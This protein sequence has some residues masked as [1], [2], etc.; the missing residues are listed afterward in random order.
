[1]DEL[2]FHG[3]FPHQ[4]ERKKRSPFRW[5][6][7]LKPLPRLPSFKAMNAM[8]HHPTDQS[9]E[10][11]R[12]LISQMETF[13]PSLPLSRQLN[14]V[15]ANAHRNLGQY[16]QAIGVIS[17]FINNKELVS[18]NDADLAAAYY[19]RACYL[20]LSGQSQNAISDLKKCTI[21]EYALKRGSY[22]SC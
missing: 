2:R 14:I 20:V 16:E 6:A 11:I 7:A 4:S 1:L 22:S 8:Y 18:Q 5:L 19:N 12:A 10:D 21:L 3:R 9:N 15:L 13:L 17:R